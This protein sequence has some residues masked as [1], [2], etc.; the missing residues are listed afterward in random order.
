[1]FDAASGITEWTGGGLHAPS[2]PSAGETPR[3]G[4]VVEATADGFVIPEGFEATDGVFRCDEESVLA[5]DG[6]YG[7]GATL[8]SVGKSI[9]DLE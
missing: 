4:L 5:L 6:D 3:C 7:E 8:E 1:M 2:D 9:D